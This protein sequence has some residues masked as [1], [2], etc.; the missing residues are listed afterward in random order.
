MKR[1]L[2]FLLTF[3]VTPLHAAS[4]CG[5]SFKMPRGWVV[6]VVKE[7]KTECEVG[8]RP[9]AWPEIVRRSRWDDDEYALYVS[10][11]HTSWESAAEEFGFEVDD[12]TKKWGM[13]GRQ[14]TFDAVE[15]VRV[16]AF[17]G[18]SSEPWFRGFA[19]DGAELGEQSRI[20][21]GSRK[22]FLLRGANELLIGVQFNSWN[23]DIALDRSVVADA[24]I[25]SLRS[26]PASN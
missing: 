6:R 10:R 19:R 5:M 15:N 11:F 8:L 1:L 4:V 26:R 24:V 14:S 2:L 17:T 22:F 18:W 23:P 25:K 13:Y 9:A 16:G 7:S 3:A 21:S 20:Y 12:R